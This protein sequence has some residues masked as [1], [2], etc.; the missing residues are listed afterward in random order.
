MLYMERIKGAGERP[1]RGLS[2]SSRSHKYS[3]WMGN[4]K[5]PIEASWGIFWKHLTVP[6]DQ[7]I[8]AVL[9]W[10]GTTVGSH[11]VSISWQ[12]M[13]VPAIKVLQLWALY[14]PF[15]TSVSSSH[16]HCSV[17]A[18]GLTLNST[19]TQKCSS[20]FCYLFQIWRSL[21]M[22]PAGISSLCFT[23]GSTPCLTLVLSEMLFVWSMV[24]VISAEPCEV[25]HSAA[26]CSV[27]CRWL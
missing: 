21:S 12:F 6:C 8:C 27:H 1:V 7:L 13:S 24:T 16:I 11:H 10:L 4:R 22:S 14:R 5:D 9:S 15:G 3:V 17:L 19:M 23:V 25:V 2:L 26:P 18:D 20:V